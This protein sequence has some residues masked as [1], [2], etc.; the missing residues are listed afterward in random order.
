M[1]NLLTLD[2]DGSADYPIGGRNVEQQSL[3]FLGHRQDQ[4][5]CEK[6]LE[7]YK[8]SVSLLRQLE[9]LLCLEEFK[10]WQTLFTEP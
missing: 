5:R 6:L 3:A 4:W 2:D 7:L 10:E 8:S 9:L 1:S